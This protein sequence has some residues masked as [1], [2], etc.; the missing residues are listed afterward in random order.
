[1]SSL[2]DGQFGHLASAVNDPKVG[3][4]SINPRTGRIPSDSFMVGTKAQGRSAPLP[5]T[6]GMIKQYAADR[7]DV[8][9][10]QWRMLGGW[11]Q[12]GKAHLDTPKAYPTSPQG[13]VG[14]RH[15]ALREGEIAYGVLGSSKEGYMGDVNN[16]WHP[17]NMKGDI[18]PGNAA[19]ARVWADM[20][21][22]TGVTSL[23]SKRRAKE[24]GWPT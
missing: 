2:N 4:F 12:G 19:D 23:E 15:A 13:E 18:R 10:K 8:L 5:A 1:V 11:Q 22:H 17:E 9:G 20:P 24:R 14:A 6:G 21:R 7:G 16:P 3:G